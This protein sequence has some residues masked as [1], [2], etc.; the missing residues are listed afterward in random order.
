MLMLKYYGF[1]DLKLAVTQIV[2]VIKAIVTNQR[3]LKL[4]KFAL[5]ISETLKA[6]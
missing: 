6:E 5:N 2:K 1:M 4:Q 3:Y